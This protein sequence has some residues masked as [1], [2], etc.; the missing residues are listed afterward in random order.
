MMG[1]N[2]DHRSLVEL[3]A[4]SKLYGSKQILMGLSLTVHKGTC[5]AV[6]GES[7]IGKT[8]LLSILGLLQPASSGQLFID[9]VEVSQLM[10]EDLLLYRSKYFG[11]LFQRPRLVSYL[12]ALE[13]VL[14]PAR[15]TGCVDKYRTQAMSLLTRLDM[16]HEMDAMPRELSAGQQHR[17][18]LA[19]AIL[20]TPAIVLADE[21]TSDLDPHAAGIVANLLLELRRAG[22]CVI[23]ATHDMKLA[24]CS[25]VVVRLT[26]SGFEW[27]PPVEKKEDLAFPALQAEGLRHG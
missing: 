7:G 27:L 26:S 22:S 10:K 5:L 14:L 18:A 12:S 19:R 1:K 13:N 3:R 25:D 8:T 2:A 9:G 16:E 15:L 23:I 24:K 20:K 6:T 4:L 17:V 21:P 11:Y